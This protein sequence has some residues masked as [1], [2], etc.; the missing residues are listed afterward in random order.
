MRKF[1]LLRS[2]IQVQSGP[3]TVRGTDSVRLTGVTNPTALSVRVYGNTGRTG[4]ATGGV[5][6]K[7]AGKYEVR[8]H[9]HDGCI[10]DYDSFTSTFNAALNAPTTMGSIS[11]EIA[12]GI[13]TY[14]FTD[15]RAYAFVKTFNQFFR[16]GWVYTLAV[17][18]L[19]E[20][21]ASTVALPFAFTY[22]DGSTE[23]AI[24]TAEANPDGSANAIFHTA[25]GKNVTSLSIRG[26]DTQTHA[27]DLSSLCIL[28]GEKTYADRKPYR[29]KLHSLTFS[30]PFFAVGEKREYVEFT[31][32]S[33]KKYFSSM[34]APT[35]GLTLVSSTG[36]SV[37]SYSVSPAAKSGTPYVLIGFTPVETLEEVS[38]GNYRCMLSEDGRKMYLSFES[39]VRSV[40]SASAKISGLS[41]L[42]VYE[43][44]GETSGNRGGTMPPLPLGEGYVDVLSAI[45]PSLM[46]VIYE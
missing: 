21:G 8:I 31:N 44:A 14:T 28:V 22:S 39:G 6:D 37:F 32:G 4:N 9:V 18:V 5:G 2:L 38:A 17:R 13:F 40:N 16:T 23:Q 3:R 12:D 30:A 24:A 41:P 43:T 42:L 35:G 7:T 20:S 25:R 10:F 34:A 11:A 33:Y 36:I 29:G 46:E 26:A 27:L 45:S 19:G 15:Q 1:D